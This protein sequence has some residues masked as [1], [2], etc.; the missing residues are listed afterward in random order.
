M[1]Q[2]IKELVAKL[3]N[4]SSE[5]KVALV[6]GENGL[7][8]VDFWPPPSSH[9]S[10]NKHRTSSKFHVKCILENLSSKPE[11]GGGWRLWMVHSE[12]DKVKANEMLLQNIQDLN[13]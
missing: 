5:P 4:L 12:E 3:D 7:P 10:L 9:D 11:E 8:Q 2:Q 1:V 13:G 6:K